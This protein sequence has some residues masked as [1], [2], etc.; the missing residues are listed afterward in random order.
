M[1]SKP[2]SFSILVKYIFLNLFVPLHISYTLYVVPYTGIIYTI[3]Y[4]FDVISA[5]F[6]LLTLRS[7]LPFNVKTRQWFPSLMCPSPIFNA[8]VR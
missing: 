7:V 2:D 1:F 8:L 6:S 3:F 4:L 5:T